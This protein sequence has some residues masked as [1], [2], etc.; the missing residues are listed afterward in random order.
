MQNDETTRAVPDAPT[1]LADEEFSETLSALTNALDALI[2][3]WSAHPDRPPDL[4]RFIPREGPSR[5]MTLVELVKV[6][7][8]YRWTDRR[9]PKTLDAYGD[10]F[11]ELAKDR[12]SADL[13]YEEFHYRARAGDEVT[14]EGYLKQYPV[15]AGDLA[16]LLQLDDPFQSTRI[17]QGRAEVTVESFE[18]GDELDD[19]S[20]LLKLGEGAFAKVFLARQQSMQRLVALKISS[21]SGTE[22]QVL[23]QLDHDHIVRVFDVRTLAGSG[24]RLLYMQY[25]PGGTLLDIVRVRKHTDNRQVDG[26][27]FGR[28]LKAALESRGETL[29]TSRSYEDSSWS[30]LICR[31]GTGLARGLAYAHRR[32][33][34]H[35]DIKPA[36]VLLTADGTP[37][38]ADFNISFGSDVEG[39]TADSFF[40]GSLAYMSPEQLAACHPARPIAPDELDARSDIYSLGVMLWELLTGERPFD[41]PVTGRDRLTL[42]DEMIERRQ[43]GPDPESLDASGTCTNGLRNALLRC[44]DPNPEHR[45]DSGERLAE[46]LELCLNPRAEEIVYAPEGALRSWLRRLAP[47]A[48][49]VLAGTPN[50]LAAFF[51]YSY[52]RLVIIDSIKAVGLAD[53]FELLQTCVNAVFFPLGLG[54]GIAYA[55][56]TCRASS[57]AARGVRK[58]DKYLT[59]HKRQALDFGHVASLISVTLWTIAAMIYPA[60]IRIMHGPG[61]RTIEYVEFFG[62]LVLCGLI[63]AAYPFFLVTFYSV[64]VLYPPLLRVNLDLQTDQALLT[65]LRQ[66]CW[67]Y[68]GIAALIPLL[69]VMALT[70][71]ALYDADAARQTGW[72]LVS[73]SAGGLCGSGLAALLFRKI[74]GDFDALLSAAPR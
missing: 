2:A 42:L 34:L 71:L 18:P 55:W 24:I 31:I 3:D 61:I 28:A 54:I 25:L 15:Q 45:F 62:S 74:L 8:E 16:R 36:N 43:A 50:G 64:R 38:L 72:V 52:N 12:L 68:L 49:I 21:D 41:D 47:L 69:S 22:P 5:L 10:E 23:A 56:A 20:L 73:L 33:V 70:S 32:G 60:A 27:V 46:Q 57:R 40:G 26:R 13:I 30:R 4:G 44:L 59:R 48:F 67:V 37:K 63:A 58:P 17:Y 29:P 14:R 9:H 65:R 39:A 51:N 7:L 1:H 53:R 19:F 6:D 11:P 66:W 35:R